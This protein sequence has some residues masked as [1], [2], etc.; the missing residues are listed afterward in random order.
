[1]NSGSGGSDDPGSPDDPGRSGGGGGGGGSKVFSFMTGNPSLPKGK[2]R[3][4]VGVEFELTLAVSRRHRNM[5][6]PHPN[7]GRW[8]SDNL[9]DE[10]DNN[11]AYRVTIRNLVI[12]TLR[13]YGVVANKTRE[14]ELAI[15]NR[16]DRDVLVDLEE[17]KECI[18]YPRLAD[19]QPRYEW[20][21]TANL[22]DNSITAAQ[23]MGEQFIQFHSDNGLEFFRTRPESLGKIAEEKLLNGMQNIPEPN[24]TKN[25]EINAHLK[26]HWLQ[27]LR[28]KRKQFVE[29]EAQHVDDHAVQVPGVDPRYY[30]WTCSVDYSIEVDEIETEH[31]RVTPETFDPGPVGLN[32]HSNTPIFRYKWWPGELKSPIYDYNNPAT[33]D[34]IRK[35]CAAVRDVYRIH[36]PMSALGMGLHIHFGQEGG[37][38]LLQL[39]KFTT[40]WLIAEPLLE[41]LHREDR[42][43]NFYGM[44][45]RQVSPIS[46]GLSS[47]ASDP[48]TRRAR[49]NLP[50]T[51]NRNPLLAYEYEVLMGLH[52]PFDEP[53]SATFN[54]H[55]RNMVTQVWL[56]DTITGLNNGMTNPTDYGY[57]KYRVD[58]GKISGDAKTVF[59]TL[60]VRLMQGTL[61]ADHVW[62]WMSICEAMIRFSTE[63]TP[64]QFQNGLRGIITL[65]QAIQD[66]IGVPSD[67][68]TWFIERQNERGYF[69]Y[70]DQDIVDWSNP[71]MAPGYAD[72]YTGFSSLQTLPTANTQG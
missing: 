31:Y 68:Y 20:E 43:Y 64:E 4:T 71:F 42:L 46:V 10:D 41:R 48:F 37:W 49:E 29:N 55:I 21:P 27:Y 28:D 2:N 45:L 33:L 61:D 40:F 50:D 26:S 12:D 9:I 51:E 69:E 5:Q 38:T 15:A 17:G 53:P 60:E 25:Q 3:T 16:F 6:D 34:T 56:Y 30:A 24:D 47:N 67:Y 70:P 65:S 58:G 32:G 52:V 7:E 35:A 14:F 66:V 39:K 11:W 13:S 62:R 44:P 1:M 36:K 19:W 18:N 8:L 57:I 23:E 59:Q 22:V 72:L 63:S 54:N